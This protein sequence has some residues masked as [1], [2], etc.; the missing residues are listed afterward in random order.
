MTSS[1]CDVT[2]TAGYT[3]WCRFGQPMGS[4]E[5]PTKSSGA[6]L[7]LSTGQPA[8]SN[9][10]CYG[11]TPA[12]ANDG[13]TSQA[14]PNEF[15]SC[16][17]YDDEWWG[18]EL[19]SLTRNPTI[20]FYARQCCTGDYGNELRFLIG[21][22]GDWNEATL[23]NTL[24]VADSGVYEFECRGEGS[25][26]F[27]MADG[28]LELPEVIVTGPSTGPSAQGSCFEQLARGGFETVCCGNGGCPA[29]D[30]LPDTCTA[31]CAA[32][33]VP[34]WADCSGL[35]ANTG[36]EANMQAFASQCAGV[37]GDP[38]DL[39]TNQP[40]VS[41]SLCYGTEGPH[42][43]NDGDMSRAHP[44]QFHSCGP[45]DNAWWG[46]Q[47]S[48]A[49]TDPQITFYAR[50]C[51]TEDFSHTLTF[52]IGYGDSPDYASPCARSTDITDGSTT[53]VSCIG[54]GDYVFVSASGYLEMPEITVM[55]IP[56]LTEPEWIP[57]SVD[58][59]VQASIFH[60]NGP[61][62]CILRDDSCAWNA[63][64]SADVNGPLS[65]WIAYDLGEMVTISGLRLR[66]HPA[67]EMP[68]DCI[69][70]SSGT[71]LDGPWRDVFSFVAAQVA[72]EQT[73]S[74]DAG[75]SGT[76]QYWRLMVTNTYG[77]LEG[78]QTAGAYIYYASFFGAPSEYTNEC[79]T[80]MEDLDTRF[81]ALCDPTAN[82]FNPV[83]P[84]TCSA[85]CAAMFVPFFEQC[86]HMFHGSADG[87]AM[88]RFYETCS[89]PN[90]LPDLST[91]QP[92]RASSS[93]YGTSPG[94]ANDGDLS[95]AH[96]LEH[97]SC[98]PSESEW[99]AVQLSG[100]TSNPTITLYA[101]DCCTSDYGNTLQIYLTDSF[102][103]PMSSAAP[104]LTLSGIADGTTPTG[105]CTGTGSHVFVVGNSYI[106]LPEVVVSGVSTESVQD[107][108]TGQPATSNSICYGTTP[109][110][111]NDG[112]TS[113]AHPNE[114]H[115]CGPYDDEW[116]GVELSSL[117]RNPTIQFY[118]RQC[119]TGDYGN[120]LRF[121][122]GPSGDWNEATLCNTLAVA[123]SGVYE[124]ECRGEGSFVF[125]MA[126]GYLELPEVIVTGPSTGPS[127][128]GSCFEQL[129]RG[130]FE[131][132]CCGNGGCPADDI[133]PDTC[134]AACA[135]VF[136]PFWADCSGLYANTGDEANMQAFASQCAGVSGDPVDLSTNQP[137]VSSSLCYGTEG[138]HLANDGDMSRAHPNQFHSCGPEDNAWWGVQLSAA[139]T[140]P[141]ITFYARDCC[142][143]DFSHT[144]TFHIGYGDS[145]DYAS[146][147]ARST[148][149]TDGSTTGVS[150]IGAGD[151]VFV[152]AS[153][154][155]EMPE[156]TVMG[157]PMLTEPEWI[158]ASV[159]W[160]VQASIFHPN[161]P[162]DCIL[163]D[164]SC[165]WNAHYS[166]DVNGPLS[167]WIAYD[168]GE[169]VTISGL[170]LRAHPAGEMP[171]DCIL[172]S[173]GT[174]LDGPWRDVF[175][176][177]AAQVAD[178][179]TFSADAG[180]SG[181]AQYWRLM[182]TNTYGGLEGAQT[183]GA[184]I[185]YVSFFGAPAVDYEYPCWDQYDA[186]DTA[187][188]TLA[189]GGGQTTSDTFTTCDDG[190]GVVFVPFF[191]QC[192]HLFHG[193][194]EATRMARLYEL[195]SG[196]T[197]PP[198]DLSTGQPVQASSSGYGTNPS[199]AND[200]DISRSHPS[201]H[202]SSPEEEENSWWMVELRGATTNPSVKFYARDC[203]TVDFEH[204]LR[205]Y[206]TDRSTPPNF[207]SVAPCLTWSDVQDG[208][209]YEDE[210]SGEGS[211]V[212]VVSN[213]VLTLPEVTV[214]GPCAGD[215]CP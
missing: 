203:C 66:A 132:V 179:Q 107:L 115:S 27:V 180:V 64:Y 103:P 48:A 168:L 169:M 4:G 150:C 10:I 128:Q 193:S 21:P 204:T 42:L 147:C 143:E 13:D 144:L 72:D 171:H 166:A 51:C 70:Q 6:V 185:Y 30:I 215:G 155:L 121:L 100:T 152:S 31:A 79:W 209:T 40:A 164:D 32:V 213:G 183:A 54:A 110:S 163:R 162:P 187:C 192:S 99:W 106:E 85:E 206:L 146:P 57:A 108:S 184:Y 197:L 141:Q 178:E 207:G 67:G 52:H 96:P 122:I 134:T 135:A 50:D 3:L 35:Y 190:C 148:D 38:V 195:C 45:E 165:A 47:L 102:A 202:C 211:F 9:S 37:S 53:G 44:N 89:N 49:T 149:I 160:T 60:P 95:R 39:S 63:H 41:S 8:T 174:G 181:T 12:S 130:G 105:T 205:V 90:A 11:T 120:E 97:H 71:G 28:Y 124:F 83:L 73:F 154:Y 117:T 7:D 158:P 210:C 208:G 186:V 43:A 191:E 212:F 127:A 74:A 161:G 77:G 20:Q 82:P 56:M 34:F 98:G 133:L 188:G 114:F 65:Q 123:D 68:H 46:V 91:A 126:D 140:D 59:T 131:T 157:I 24:A 137:A 112:D 118:A 172:Q 62:D 2:A 18:V 29:D 36:D 119:C 80:G 111:A 199:S 61:P 136:V 177:V 173:S 113:Q 142:T 58:W 101:R 15:H 81:T 159:D 175:S 139:T 19:S 125:V 75:V 92:V 189:A 214:S 5:C 201:E 129:A 170:R 87:P 17:P 93:C 198:P 156:I 196:T 25:F 16:G 1:T 116:W 26:V 153:G 138:P 145:P 194:G 167:Q 176:F 151:Y 23:C 84:P 55:G 86:S 33:F 94:L 182:V 76:A 69:L 109:A 14:H 104:C 78:A 88:A 22:S 200:G